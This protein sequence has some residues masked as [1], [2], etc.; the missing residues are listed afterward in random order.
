MASYQEQVSGLPEWYNQ[1]YHQMQNLGMTGLAQ[2]FQGYS[3]QLVAGLMPYQNQ[4]GQMAQNLPGSYQPHMQQASGLISGSAQASPTLGANY[5]AMTGAGQSQF[6]GAQGAIQ[7]AMGANLAGAGAPQYGQAQSLYTSGSQFD[8]NKLAQHFNP[9]VSNVVQELGRLGGEQFTNVIN[10][11]LTSSFQGLGQ[12]GSSRQAALLADAAAKSQREILGQQ[13]NALNTGYGM[14]QQDYLNWAQQGSNAAAGLAGLGQ[15]NYNQLL[16]QANL[17][18]QGAGQLAGIG[19][20]MI[21]RQQGASQLQEQG[22]QNQLGN[23]LS[24]GTSMGNLGQAVQQS[25]LADI[26]ALTAAGKSQQENAQQ[27]LD[28]QYNEFL[29]QQQYPFLQAEAFGKMFPAAPTSSTSWSTSF[30]K[31]GLAR[32]ADGGRFPDP[33][34]ILDRM[35]ADGLT[36]EEIARDFDTGGE[37]YRSRLVP[38]IRR[39]Q[40]ILRAEEDSTI[41]PS[42]QSNLM[43]RAFDERVKLLE[44][45]RNAEYLQ[46]MD[47]GSTIGN[48]GEALLRASAEGPAHWGQLLGRAGASYFGK[49][50]AVRNENKSRELARLALEEKITPDVGRA[51]GLGSG[52]MPGYVSVIGQD[53]KRYMVNRLNPNDRIEIGTGVNQGSLHDAADR[54]AREQIKDSIFKDDAEREARYNYHKQQYIGSRTGDGSMFPAAPGSTLKPGRAY[55][56]SSYGAPEPEM[57]VDKAGKV[58]LSPS[59]EEQQ[60]KIGASEGARYDEMQ[61]VG[62]A[63]RGQLNT[64]N[65]LESNLDDITTGKLTPLKTDVK[66]WAKAFNIDLGNEDVPPAQAVQAIS[67]QLALTLRNT[68]EGNGMPGALSDNDLKFLKSMVPNLGNDHESNKRIIN[69]S[70]KISQRNAEVAQKARDYIQ[71]N[72]RGVLDAG[73]YRDFEKWTKANPLF[74]S[75]QKSSQKEFDEMPDASLYDGK[76][77]KGDDGTIYRSVNGQWVKEGGK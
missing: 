43:Q 62:A 55:D 63:S 70:R 42:A 17:G 2:P 51:G 69:Y 15:Q 65:Y 30:K 29:R 41:A 57:P 44:R 23:Q 24:A 5:N 14:A 68:S 66:A 6:T 39:P 25:G 67:G 54:Y 34:S 7:G 58:I 19:G 52:A 31:G 16:G 76:R 46:P 47:E 56:Q 4:A 50:D 64:L 33:M 11:A 71:N 20:Q 32:Y 35:R 73:F 27:Y 72:P 49:Q 77:L 60:K 12:Q 10:P 61:K 13:G 75:E 36:D 45:V 26:G 48:I 37:T 8:P 74:E 40:D 1:G 22:W 21:G 59:E 28:K 38:A 9:Y 18:L 3:G 53:G